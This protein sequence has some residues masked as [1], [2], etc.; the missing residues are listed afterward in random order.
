MVHIRFLVMRRIQS[1]HSITGKYI[2][3]S[4]FLCECVTG[5]TLAT[6]GLVAT[7]VTSGGLKIPT[8]WAS[9]ATGV[10]QGD[11][12]GIANHVPIAKRTTH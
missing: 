8:N 3:R 2:Y 1:M 10:N 9:Y 5:V 7:D 6:P 12:E 4:S 11:G